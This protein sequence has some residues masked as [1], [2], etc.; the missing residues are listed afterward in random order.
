MIKN[1]LAIFI[2]TT[3]F[4][5]VNAQLDKGTL[6]IG[7]D[8][9]FG[10]GFSKSLNSYNVYVNPNIGIFIAPKF[11]IG[12][13]VGFQSSRQSFSNSSSFISFGGANVSPFARYY[14]LKS[15][16]KF[17]LFGQ[18]SIIMGTNWSKNI[19]FPYSNRFQVSPGLSAG[20]AY[21]ISPQ[22]AL[23]ARLNYTHQF[24]SNVIM[25]GGN[26]RGTLG[27]QIHLDRKPK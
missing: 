3:L 15:E 14:F 26:F 11:A 22:I 23:E 6:L 21:F 7:G 27:F 12:T 17:N 13:G 4:F 19:S 20:A 25:K 9:A 16:N 8:G 1:T 5:S 24:S 18:A 2:A 10:G